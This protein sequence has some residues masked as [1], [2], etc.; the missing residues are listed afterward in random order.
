MFELQATPILRPPLLCNGLA[1]PPSLCTCTA[2]GQPGAPRN[3]AIDA[4]V[5]TLTVQWDPPAVSDTASSYTIKIYHDADDSTFTNAAAGTWAS[6][7]WN[8]QPVTPGLVLGDNS[9][10]ENPQPGFRYTLPTPTGL[11][12]GKPRVLRAESPPRSAACTARVAQPACLASAVEDRLQLK[13]Q[14]GIWQC[15]GA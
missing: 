7:P 13:Y 8:N 3:V 15:A 6:I 1:H 4:G 5:S 10:P 12:N 9:D 11:T 2:A 14:A